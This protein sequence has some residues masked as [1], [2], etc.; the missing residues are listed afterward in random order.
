MARRVTQGAV[1]VMAFISNFADQAVVLPLA[2]ITACALCL[3]RWWRG[4]VAWCVAVPGTLAAMLAL[5]IMGIELA[6]HLG[7]PVALSPSGHVAA[8]C[9]V[10][11]GLAVLAGRGRVPGALLGLAPLS[12]VAVI[13]VSRIRLGAHTPFEVVVGAVVGL[14][15]VAVLAR[16]AGERPQRN[17]WP[18][19]AALSGTVLALHGMH[20]PA[21]QVIRQAFWVH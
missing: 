11:G 14:I 12:A 18:L 9:V 6:L 15:G 21:E 13:G 3:V 17:A 2:V 20:M 8:G 5:K 10:Y 1:A 16:L 4:L 7:W 19:L